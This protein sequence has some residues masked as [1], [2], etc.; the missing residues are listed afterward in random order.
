MPN[1]YCK[2]RT[3]FTLI[4]LLVVIAIIA[5]LIALLVPAVQRVREAAARI[6]CVNNVKQ[7]VLSVH[8][9]HDAY[10]K[11]PNMQNWNSSGRMIEGQTES[12]QNADWNGGTTCA[13]GAT[14]TWLVHVLPY[15]DQAALWQK[16]FW[17]D[18]KPMV[19]NSALSYPPYT[20][21]A[22][23]ILP[24]FLCPSDFTI[25]NGGAQQ[26]G[27]GSASYS[28]NVMVFDPIAPKSLLNA[29]PHGT[30]NTV[31]IAER[32]MNCG[33]TDTSN[34]S[35][36]N[37]AG[38]L[39][40]FFDSPAWAFIWP[41]KGSGTTTPGFGWYTAGYKKQWN[42]TGGFQTDFS[43]I[44]PKGSVPIA[45]QTVPSAGNCWAGVTQTAHS[46]G[47]VAGL[48]DG[49]VRTISPTISVTTWVRACTPNDGNPLG[50]DW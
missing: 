19:F 14:G 17:S 40:S 29:M 28:G 39:V 2:R 37:Y 25:M 38:E 45:F 4:E 33:T 20:T 15:I 35:D 7:I 24:I 13:D 44:P 21:Y 27:W 32:Y 1:T 46:A 42:V 18:Q 36:P 50:S 8:T 11:L 41:L 43:G 48:G 23:T 47:M 34:S 26:D 6:Q 5:T 10:R 49:S 16:M 9:Y 3:G 12:I 22:K 31:I 30:S